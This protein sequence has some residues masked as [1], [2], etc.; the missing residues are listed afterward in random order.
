MRIALS[1]ALLVAVLASAAGTAMAAP[2]PS[3]PQWSEVAEVG[4]VEV[5]TVD[6]DGSPRE[7]TVWLA[8]VDGQGYL[9]TGGT[10]WGGNLERDPQLVLRIEEREYALRSEAVEDEALR[11]RITAAFREK[12]GFTDALIGLVRGDHPMI[13][14]LLPR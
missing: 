10:R 9:R 7:T 11:E 1:R 6:E 13:M 2:E 5:L 4:T 14:R 12:Y 3:P 8:V